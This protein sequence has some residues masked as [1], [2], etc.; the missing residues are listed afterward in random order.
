MVNS[1]QFYVCNVFYGLTI[2]KIILLWKAEKITIAIFV[3]NSLAWGMN[4]LEE[5]ILRC[6]RRLQI[7]CHIQLL[8]YTSWNT[9]SIRVTGLWMILT[10]FQIIPKLS[11]FFIF[12]NLPTIFL[13][14]TFPS[15]LE[16]RS[17][18]YGL[19]KPPS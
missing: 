9:N 18:G 3:R 2:T 12:W 14:K 4:E 5:E 11:V 7:I 15:P 8:K 6:I 10:I 16:R 17:C 13:L 1:Y 19:T